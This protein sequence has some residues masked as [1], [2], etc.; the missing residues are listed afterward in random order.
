MQSVSMRS[1]RGVEEGRSMSDSDHGAVELSF[2]PTD[3]LLFFSSRSL[4]RIFGNALLVREK[5]EGTGRKN[6]RLSS[7]GKK[8]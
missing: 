2:F 6:Y 5:K 8:I 4:M 3:S 1:D 7:W